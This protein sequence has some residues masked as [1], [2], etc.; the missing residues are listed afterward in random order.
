MF[1]GHGFGANIVHGIPGAN[2]KSH[3]VHTTSSAKVFGSILKTRIRKSITGTAKNMVTPATAFL[4]PEAVTL[5][6]AF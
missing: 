2:S 4:A 6:W 5:L 1:F 3:P